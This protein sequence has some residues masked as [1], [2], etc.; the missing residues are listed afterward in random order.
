MVHYL[1][2]ILFLFA[3][4]LGIYFFGYAARNYSLTLITSYEII[5]GLILILP[6]LL[7]YEGLSFHDLFFKPTKANYIFLGVAGLFGY[8]GGNYFSLQNLKILGERTNSLLSPAITVLTIIGGVVIFN[9]HITLFKILGIMITIISI[10][11]FVY[12]QNKNEVEIKK[13]NSAFISCIA[14]I[15]CIVISIILSI[16]GTIDSEISILHSIGL[17]LLMVIP[18]TMIFIIKNKF[19]IGLKFHSKTLLAV[20]LGVIAQTIIASYLW[21]YCTNEMRISNFQIFISTLPFF[22]YAI[23]VYYLKKTKPSFTFILS[24][25]FAIIGIVIVLN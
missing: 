21:F 8:V 23:D 1:L 9:E 25:F 12:F 20:V 10:F 11:Y 19:S 16:K 7:F 18:F 15:A 17:R 2:P 24:A 13:N 5:I 3:L 6:I 14:T 22:V 4:I